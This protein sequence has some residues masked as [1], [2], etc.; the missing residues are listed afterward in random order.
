[1]NLNLNFQNKSFS[2]QEPSGWFP[3]EMKF[4]FWSGWSIFMV[5]RK[6][7]SGGR[8]PVS[9]RLSQDHFL[10]LR[11]ATSWIPVQFW[12]RFWS[13]DRSLP[14]PRTVPGSRALTPRSVSSVRRVA[15]LKTKKKCK[16]L[17]CVNK[18]LSEILFY[19]WTEGEQR[20]L[21]EKNFHLVSF[22]CKTQKV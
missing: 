13:K 15:G 18:K 16:Y 12:V 11:R 5:V 1:M 3:A 17:K 21:K 9:P 4:W 10:G 14:G 8:S 7:S 6:P 22:I 19:V 2:L 20:H